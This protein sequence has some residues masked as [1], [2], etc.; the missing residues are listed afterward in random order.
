MQLWLRNLLDVDCDGLSDRR[1][2]VD[3][4]NFLGVISFLRSCYSDLCKNRC[5]VDPDQ[6]RHDRDPNKE[7]KS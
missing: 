3:H 6:I 5:D 4:C 2:R 1:L 7:S